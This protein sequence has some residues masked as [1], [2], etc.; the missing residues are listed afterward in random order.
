MLMVGVDTGKG[1]RGEG[2]DLY[3]KEIDSLHA[4][5]PSLQGECRLL[6]PSFASWCFTMKGFREN[7]PRKDGLRGK[8]LREK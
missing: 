5:E 3:P 4:L 1:Q 7:S 8:V 2:D 6:G